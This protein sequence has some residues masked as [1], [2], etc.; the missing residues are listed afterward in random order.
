MEGSCREIEGSVAAVEGSCV[1]MWTSFL[2]IVGS[3]AE[4]VGSFAEIEKVSNSSCI[5]SLFAMCDVCE[6][7]LAL[8]G[9]ALSW[10]LARQV[11]PMCSSVAD[12]CLR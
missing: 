10:W 4:I 3:F 11:H 1:E 12:F 2:E 7:S 5:R 9:A 6:D 8:E